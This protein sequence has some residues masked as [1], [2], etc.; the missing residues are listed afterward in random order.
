ML[1]P[2]PRFYMRPHMIINY[3]QNMMSGNSLLWK[4]EM[5]L[6][7]R[8]RVFWLLGTSTKSNL[9]PELLLSVVRSS[10]LSLLRKD[11]G[12]LVLCYCYVVQYFL[13]NYLNSF[14]KSG[15]EICANNN[16]HNF[17]W[18]ASLPTVLL[19]LSL[20]LCTGHVCTDPLQATFT[21]WVFLSGCL[22]WFKYQQ[23]AVKYRREFQQL[24]WTPHTDKSLKTD[25]ESAFI[26]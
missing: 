22:G 17:P 9:S 21:Q 10:S 20:G 1:N 26:E 14:E 8:E 11:K 12:V 24:A 23:V 2:W 16:A 5:S 18:A 3:T 7:T 15:I 6:S 19:W 13:I 4:T 25:F